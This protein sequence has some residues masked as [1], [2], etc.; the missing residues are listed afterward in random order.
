MG[1]IY[2]ITCSIS[3]KI[4]IGQTTKTIQQRWQQH[5][6]CGKSMIKNKDNM[7]K[8]RRIQFSYLYH[9]MAYYGIHNFMIEELE[10]IDDDLLND[11]EI[12]YIAEL[13]T[14]CP[15][16]FNLSSGGLNFKHSQETIDLMKRRKH[17]FVD[18]VRNEKL[19]GLPAKTAYRNHKTKGEQ[20]LFNNH[21]L[22]KHKTF[23]T[24]KYG[25]F[26]KTKEAA[27]Q[28]YQE[29]EQSGIPYVK[30]KNG[31]DD[32]KNK[33]GFIK[34]P[35]GYRVNKVQKGINFDKRFER[36]DRTDAENKAAALEWYNNLIADLK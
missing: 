11:V 8:I 13:N 4:Y 30:P 23:S 25:T 19:Q 24:D 32:L 16:G 15:N 18:N 31:D 35:K 1:F 29:L 36:K 7:E 12:Q 28:F 2:M 26:E 22:C 20:I 21:P 3:P 34:T 6:A 10:E 33:P 14:Q 5:I 9:A 27:L 17:E